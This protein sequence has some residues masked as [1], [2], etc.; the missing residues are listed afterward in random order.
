MLLLIIAAP[1]LA[2]VVIMVGA[3]ARATA[4]GASLLTLLASVLVFLNFDHHRSGC[5][6]FDS[7]RSWNGFLGAW[8][9]DFRVEQ[10]A[11]DPPI[12]LAAGPCSV[13]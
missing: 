3:P 8:L 1:I 12:G 10:W 9:A 5:R 6:T 7:V 4:L 2:A 13:I 11:D